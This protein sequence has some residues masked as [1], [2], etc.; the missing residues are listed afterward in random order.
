MQNEALYRS[1]YSKYAPNLT[2]GELEK[3]LKYAYTLDPNEFINAF[4]KKYTGGPPTAKQSE[5]ISSII[6]TKSP[7]KD[8]IYTKPKNSQQ[9][10]E[11]VKNIRGGIDRNDPDVI[12]DIAKEYFNL[13]NLPKKYKTVHVHGHG[14]TNNPMLNQPRQ[15]E[16]EPLE[17]D[18]KNYFERLDN[19]ERTGDFT[20]YEQYKEYQRTKK[21]N[22]DWVD[23]TTI[24]RA[25]LNR[26]R[27]VTEQY[28]MNIDNDEVRDA[29]EIAAEEEV[30]SIFEPWEKKQLNKYIEL[31]KDDRLLKKQYDKDVRKFG[32]TNPY[33]EKEESLA[34][35]FLSEYLESKYSDLEADT[36]DFDGMIKD[37]ELLKTKRESE[38]KK[39]SE[40][41]KTL[42][43]DH[44]SSP[45]DI[46]KH[47]ELAKKHQDLMAE[48]EDKIKI[49]PI[50]RDKL[51]ERYKKYQNAINVATESDA[52]AKAFALNYNN[53]QRMGLHLEKAIVGDFVG[54][55]I[56]VV[57]FIASGVETVHSHRVKPIGASD[58]LL[59]TDELQDF[60]ANH[61]NYTESLERHMQSS[62]P[63]QVAWRDVSMDNIGEVSGQLFADNSFSIL[64]A[65]T[66][67]GAVARIS[68]AGT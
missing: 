48:F 60:H 20:K 6:G 63:E 56:G 28:I 65:L 26:K 38:L 16:Q 12:N 41:L 9:A 23:N 14:Q 66:Y 13:D 7:R 44:N 39:I 45:E 49:V 46:A 35:K 58:D 54:W 21:F 37:F 64:S 2:A 61:I 34:G 3:K 31:L 15:V 18:I 17:E 36:K 59:L 4:Y 57:N 32:L 42:N 25:V 8:L 40:E 1:L 67:G 27:Q 55:G 50:R 68:R 5:Y 29:A 33:A 30:F 43:A 24:S 19:G 11:S 10:I 53:L 52:V 51:L 22:L 62:L 47:N